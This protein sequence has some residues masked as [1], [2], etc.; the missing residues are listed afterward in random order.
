MMKERLLLYRTKN[1]NK[2]PERII[3]FR[4]GVSEGQFALVLAQELPSIR[5]ACQ[6]MPQPGGKPYS[7]TI[8]IVI[9][10]KRHQTRF[11][12]TEQEKGGDEKGA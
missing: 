4:D 12:A 3:V 11:F 10:A 7:P 8:T 1:A 9:C 2:L 5:K 6:A